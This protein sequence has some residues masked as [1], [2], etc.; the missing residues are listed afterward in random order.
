[1]GKGYNFFIFL[2]ERKFLLAHLIGIFGY[3]MFIF[4]CLA[5]ACRVVALGEDGCLYKAFIG[6]HRL[7]CS[8]FNATPLFIICTKF[9]FFSAYTVN[10]H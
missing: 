9:Q 4:P 7:F 5:P 10:M 2:A 1:M 6:Y 8:I 3:V